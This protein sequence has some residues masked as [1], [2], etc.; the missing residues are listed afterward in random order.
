MGPDDMPRNIHRGVVIRMF[1]IPR[2]MVSGVRD[3]IPRCVENAVRDERPPVQDLTGVPAEQSCSIRITLHPDLGPQ[4]YATAVLACQ[5]LMAMLGMDSHA[6]VW[7]DGTV[8]DDELNT[9]RDRWDRH[10]PWAP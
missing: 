2:T 10:D 3:T 1:R 4:R 6:T 8:S 7:P 9:L 5:H